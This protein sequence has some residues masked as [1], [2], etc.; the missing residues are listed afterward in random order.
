MTK[1]KL[2]PA[3][4]LQA[5]CA[6]MEEKR[7]TRRGSRRSSLDGI[8]CLD[9]ME[10]YDF[11][12]DLDHSL[13][14]RHRKARST[15]VKPAPS[16]AKLAASLSQLR[17]HPSLLPYSLTDDEV[18]AVAYLWNCA[19]HGSSRCQSWDDLISWTSLEKEDLTGSLQFIA[20]LLDKEVL[21]NE[22]G[23]DAHH[24][25]N[26][27][28]LIEG[29]FRL[30]SRFNYAL[31]NSDPSAK[32]AALLD[33][34]W[35]SK[36]DMDRDLVYARQM[37]LQHYPEL[38]SDRGRCPH[39]D[40]RMYRD[41]LSPLK[42]KLENTSQDLPLIGC[43]KETA[44]DEAELGMIVWFYLDSLL[45]RRTSWNMLV[46]LISADQASRARLTNRL[47]LEPI[48][49]RL[50]LEIKKGRGFMEDDSYLEPTAALTDRLKLKPDS[51][52][53]M[54]LDDDDEE[55][56]ASFLTEVN[57]RQSIEDLILPKANK[58]LIEASIKRFADTGDTDL[59]AWGIALPMT[60]NAASKTKGTSIF[61][62]GSP[63]TGKTFT[64]GAIANA[65]GKQLFSIDASKLRNKYYGSSQ[66]I[67]REAFRVMREMVESN[68][69]PPVFLLNEADQ[70]IHRRSSVDGNCSEV[71]NS[72]QNIFLEEMETFPGILVLTT[73]LVENIDEAYFRRFDIK[74]ELQR[75]DYECRLRIWKMHLPATIPGAEDIDCEYLARTYT[76]SG[77]QIWT[78]VLNACNEAITRS[79]EKKRLSMDD[80]VRYAN[81]ED[82]WS[83]REE[84]RPR[85][86]F[87]A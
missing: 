74:I 55:S 44:A 76:L 46:N 63:G 2:Q 28:T 64:A 33:K 43:L 56:L 13:P 21:Y 6:C 66:R 77:G 3:N 49:A 40:L 1:I 69:N 34:G 80:L 42:A 81:L 70:I 57:A 47:E 24:S 16:N 50:G 35:T 72:L 15:R 19:V 20:G 59:S 62:Y 22:D 26:L 11:V 12:E 54:S 9:D 67:L 36:R 78:I 23:Y 75:P 25:C 84:A 29:E 52:A 85:I 8:E 5:I 7:S 18:L 60:R 83:R 45:H 41:L 79:G 17:R 4:I 51:E 30:H 14:S 31:L 48:L 87:C 68:P 65:L 86:G 10:M 38:K 37:L 71:E 39:T 32:I 61:L 27:L 82:P 73:N 58:D 53:E